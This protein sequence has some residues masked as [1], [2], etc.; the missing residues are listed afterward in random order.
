MR[1]PLGT[2]GEEFELTRAYLELFAV[3]MG[4]RLRFTIELPERLAC[5]PFPRMVVLTLVDA[6]KH[7]LAPAADGGSVC[8]RADTE[9]SRLLVSVTDDGVGFGAANTGGTGIGL[10]TFAHACARSSG[11][12]AA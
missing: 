9:G 8:V 10:V 5:V 11:R 4:A 3:R 12:T 7:G 2:L 6:I 1:A